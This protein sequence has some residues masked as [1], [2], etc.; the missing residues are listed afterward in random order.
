L[1]G[2]I[3]E[4]EQR[5]ATL[6]EAQRRR[7]PTKRASG[8]AEAL[9]TK[10]RRS[11]SNAVSV[12]DRDFESAVNKSA[13]APRALLAGGVDVPAS[14]KKAPPGSVASGRTVPFLRDSSSAKKPKSKLL[15]ATV[16][17]DVIV[18]LMKTFPSR[19]FAWFCTDYM[20]SY[21]QRDKLKR[22]WEL[23]DLVAEE[24]DYAVLR[25]GASSI[26]KMRV[27]KSLTHRAEAKMFDL[28]GKVKDNKSRSTLS[29]GALGNRYGNWLRNRGVVEG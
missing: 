22:C 11:D 10:R 13:M 17:F 9:P 8:E 1:V 5:I 16:L 19:N 15:A 28:E 3:K 25:G 20:K 18:P 7:S 24:E 12:D 29:Y 27:C 26:E 21:G 23:F 6:T 14:L 4:L 2:R